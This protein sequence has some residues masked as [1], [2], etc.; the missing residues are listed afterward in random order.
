[1]LNPG[2]YDLAVTDYNMS[3]MSGVE[4]ASALREIRADLPVVLVSG[5]ITEELRAKAPAAGIRELIPSA[6]QR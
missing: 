4:M 1:M 6:R 3:G 2:Q 5:Y